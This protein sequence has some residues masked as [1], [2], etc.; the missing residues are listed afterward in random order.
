MSVFDQFNANPYIKMYAGA[1]IDEALEV[2]KIMQGRHDKALTDMQQHEYAL[3][4]IQGIGSADKAY[5]SQYAAEL[6]AE[7]EKLAEA[8]EMA[9]QAINSLAAKYKQDPTLR[10]MA[11][12]AAG[13]KEWE[14]AY[15]K[16]PS[17]YGDV[18]N[19][20]MQKAVQAYNEGGGAAEGATFKAPALKELKDVNKFVRENAALIKS[21][22]NGQFRYDEAKGSIVTTSGEA[23]SFE[24]AQSILN[25]AL[26]GDPQMREQLQRQ[27]NYSKEREGF[28]GSYTD[29]VSTNTQGVAE[30]SA[31]SKTKTDAKN[32]SNSS[33]KSKK[34]GTGEFFFTA[35]GADN[36]YGVDGENS[37]TTSFESL[38]KNR[39]KRKGTDPAALS[40]TVAENELYDNAV[41]AWASQHPNDKKTA[42]FLRTVGIDGLPTQREA[43]L[44]SVGGDMGKSYTSTTYELTMQEVT[45]YALANNIKGQELVDLKESVRKAVK[46]IY[47]PEF[48]EQVHQAGRTSYE[49]EYAPIENFNMS[50]EEEAAMN[51]V[52][53]DA[54]GN[55]GSITATV[56]GEEQEYEKGEFFTSYDNVSVK[57][58][59]GRGAGTIVIEASRNGVQG[60]DMIEYKLPD[61]VT[62]IRDYFEQL[63]VHRA[64]TA[65]NPK[66]RAAF[67]RRALAYGSPN[68][69]EQG[70]RWDS[71]GYTLGQ[72][73]PLDT[74]N[75]APIIEKVVGSPVNL[76]KDGN[77]YFKITDKNGRNIFENNEKM[78]NLLKH[79]TTGGEATAVF[80][81]NVRQ[82][83]ASL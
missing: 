68:L 71:E 56:N 82:Q 65:T 16:D 52:V 1:P 80:L 3:S 42:D 77:G 12:H 74:G 38:A 76:S 57:S 41:N 49:T 22:S 18:A 6:S 9:G 62:N 64:N 58:I 63:S 43:V 5:K 73:L 2:G 29:F 20:E 50:S 27:Y 21:S 83:L 15:A 23:V 60:S 78:T 31:F 55:A 33:G 25:A 13:M 24:R 53:K 32:W 44:R 10:A 46:N 39:K 61:G 66:E 14:E 4:N 35:K 26:M 30:A 17:K 36:V 72:E 37:T 11:S 34:G 67:T 69:V 8:P 7:F 75:L 51:T 28:K 70:A 54:M 79:S 40:A 59:E 48:G 45:D 47:T 81:N 19:Y